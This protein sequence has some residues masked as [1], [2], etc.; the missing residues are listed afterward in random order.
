MIAFSEQSSD[1]TSTSSVRP[2]FFSQEFTEEAAAKGTFKLA[3][4]VTVS[5]KLW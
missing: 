5:Y 4:L 3:K 2:D 1:P